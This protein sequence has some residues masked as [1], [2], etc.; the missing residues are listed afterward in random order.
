MGKHTLGPWKMIAYPLNETSWL[1]KVEPQDSAILPAFYK[2]QFTLSNN[3]T[4]PLDTFLN[5][6]G[7]KKVCYPTV[8]QSKLIIYTILL[9]A[10]CFKGVAFVNGI[11]IGRYWPSAGPQITLYVP[12]TYLIPAPGVNTIVMLELEDVPQDLSISL[13]DKPILNSSIDFI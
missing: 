4:K 8:I 12:A 3:S 13:V 7:W 2:T 9:I 6:S 11:N 1:S 5:T 10:L